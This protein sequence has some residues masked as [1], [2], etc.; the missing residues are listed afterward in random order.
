MNRNCK[1]GDV[2]YW[3][4]RRSDDVSNLGN[5][6]VTIIS[7]DEEGSIEILGAAFVIYGHQDTAICVGASHSFDAPRRRKESRQSRRDMSHLPGIQEYSFREY[8]P[9]AIFV[10]V[11][12]SGQ[13]YVCKIGTHNSLDGYDVTVFTVSE[14]N[15]S[16]LFNW[17]FNLDFSVPS[18]GDKVGAFVRDVK[19]EGA[20]A[21][22]AR[23][24]FDLH[25]REG[26][27]TEVIWETDGA[28]FLPGQ[29]FIVRTTIPMEGGMSGS[30]MI[31]FDREGDGCSVWGVVSSDRSD[32][33]A[34][35]KFSLAGDSA[36]SMLWPA[37]GLSINVSLDPEKPKDTH[38]LLG[39]IIK[40]GAIEAGANGVSVDV[41]GDKRK[42][43]VR[44]CDSR[45]DQGQNCVLTTKG[46]PFL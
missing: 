6:L 23:A 12:R 30:P 38:T 45:S 26:F 7:F 13:P 21:G 31:W 41:Y 28:N 22:S 24:K 17:K 4:I 29:S 33:A 44:Y 11:V 18:V 35:S 15:G 25:M 19:L 37:L 20:E 3:H 10:M 40:S 16:D 46:H 32:D 43:E 36:A 34:K 2:K 1:M 27:V 8:D 39:D 14:P 5:A 9:H 42:I